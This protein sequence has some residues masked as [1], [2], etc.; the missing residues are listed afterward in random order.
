VIVGRAVTWTTNDDHIAKVSDT[1]LV[2]ARRSGTVTI[3]A[4]IDG[5]SGSAKVRITN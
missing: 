4:T 3:T 1:G 5:R 2:T